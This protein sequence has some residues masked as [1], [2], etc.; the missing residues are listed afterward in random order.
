LLGNVCRG[1]NDYVVKVFGIKDGA[2]QMLAEK[3]ISLESAV[4]IRSQPDLSV[5]RF[6]DSHTLSAARSI[7][8]RSLLPKRIFPSPEFRTACLES[9]IFSGNT[10][11]EVYANVAVD[12]D[13]IS[14]NMPS[15]TGQNVFQAQ[16][17]W[18]DHREGTLMQSAAIIPYPLGACD[19][20]SSIEVWSPTHDR[21]FVQQGDSVRIQFFNG[22]QWTN[23][24]EHLLRLV[25]IDTDDLH[26]L[27]LAV[28]ENEFSLSE[29]NETRN[30]Y[31]NN[32][33]DLFTE[34][35]G[36]YLFSLNDGAFLGVVWHRRR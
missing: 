29:T 15:T 12:L 27:R 31:S 10:P 19:S 36:E 14:G 6:M 13:V 11:V 26:S 24:R 20:F 33:S 21:A 32:Q 23:A 1:H 4:G 28:T 18:F 5:L 22:Q 7:E 2:Q 35:R 8:S 3:N 25:P 16:T 30:G 9:R 34:Q 17:S